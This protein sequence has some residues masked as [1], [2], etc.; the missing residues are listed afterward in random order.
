MLYLVCTTI[1]RIDH[2]RYE[3]P[4]AQ[5]LG[6]CIWGSCY[7]SSFCATVI[8]VICATGKNINSRFRFKIKTSYIISTEGDVRKVTVLAA[9][10]T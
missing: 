2:A 4:Y 10:A 1:S 9:E 8:N 7:N 5:E 3:V 6:A